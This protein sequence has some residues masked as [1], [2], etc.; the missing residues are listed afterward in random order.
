MKCDEETHIKRFKFPFVN[1]SPRPAVRHS[2]PNDN[3]YIQQYSITQ[4]GYRSRSA[5]QRKNSDISDNGKDIQPV[6]A[7]RNLFAYKDTSSPTMLSRRNFPMA[8][9]LA[10]NSPIKEVRSN[11]SV[12][13]VNLNREDSFFDKVMAYEKSKEN[14]LKNG[15]NGNIRY[16]KN[17]EMIKTP[18][19]TSQEP[20]SSGHIL[21]PQTSVKNSYQTPQNEPITPSL[22]IGQNVKYPNNL[23][24]NDFTN[25][26]NNIDKIII[27]SKN[28]SNDEKLSPSGFSLK[29][30]INTDQKSVSRP[31]S[32]YFKWKEHLIKVF[33]YTTVEWPKFEISQRFLG[34]QNNDIAE[35][36]NKYG[37]A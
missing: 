10:Q 6:P 14:G 28:A 16:A 33:L 7:K 24:G 5:A 9:Q 36:A 15:S 37:K 31:C 2:L 26:L 3:E 18:R 8:P 22:Q 12:H 25:R 35:R 17:F 13:A 20:I 34:L 29:S 32:S 19:S 11:D 27:P 23:S 1:H 30:P 4:D 21:N